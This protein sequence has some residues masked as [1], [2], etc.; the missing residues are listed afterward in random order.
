MGFV[1]GFIGLPN[2]GKSTIFN[3]LGAARAEVA[4]YPFCT[5][6]PNQGI[7]PV[8]DERLENLARLLKPEKITP[9]LLEFW[10]IAGLVKGANQG[11][12]LGNQFLGHIRNVDALAHVVRCFGDDKVTHVYGSVEPRRDIEIIQTELILADLQTV[13][14]RLAKSVHQGKV[15]DKKSA[16]EIPHLEEIRTGLSRGSPAA[17]VALAEEGRSVLRLLD[18]LTAKPVLY[19][20][21]A[22]EKELKERGCIPA[23]EKLAAGENVPVVIVCGALEAEI[24]ELPPAE[25]SDFLKEMGLAESALNQL[26]RAGYHLL[27]LVTFYTT[28]GTELRAWTVPRGTPAPRAAGKIHTDM[29]QGFI[30]AEVI[31][32]PE[33]V[34]AGSMA[35]ARE[36]GMVRVEGKDYIVQDG[37]ILHIRFHA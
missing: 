6:K 22:D 31:S 28:V 11:E 29:E 21:N 37:D 20:V 15:G 4:S 7:A 14:K 30:R 18:L 5:I 25:R 13:E 36:K 23:V 9:T 16:A 3:A 19:V 27:N 24:A 34:S 35:A 1:C 10:D 17:A 33:F 8:P 26:I 32:Y 2:A 12:G